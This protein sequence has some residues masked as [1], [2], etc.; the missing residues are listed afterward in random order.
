MLP[1]YRSREHLIIPSLDLNE[2]HGITNGLVT[3]APSLCPERP[4]FVYAVTGKATF[5]H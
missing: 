1:P 3:H 2:A 5:N 4:G